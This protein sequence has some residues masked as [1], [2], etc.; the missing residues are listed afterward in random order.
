MQVFQKDGTWVR[1]IYVAEGTPAERLGP[2]QCGGVGTRKELPPCG[3]MYK[4]VISKDPEQKFLYVAD[5]A[6]SSVW[7]VDRQSGETLGSF[8]GNGRYAGQL[9]WV[10][11]IAT[12]SDGNI[13][14]GEVEHAKRIQKF[15]PVWQ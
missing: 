1:D 15:V 6:N 13:Y 11:A 4:M 8:G 3:T 5:T 9:H 14:T 2:T 10:N 7:I 12:D